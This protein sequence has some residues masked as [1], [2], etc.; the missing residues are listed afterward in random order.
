MENNNIKD[1]GIIRHKAE[2]KALQNNC[3]QCERCDSN[4]NTATEVLKFKGLK[5]LILIANVCNR[6][7]IMLQKLGWYY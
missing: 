6:C 3:P 2:I 7:A 5:K 1:M 4:N